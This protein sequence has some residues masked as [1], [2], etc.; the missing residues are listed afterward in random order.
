VAIGNN[1]ELK[2][3]VITPTEHATTLELEILLNNEKSYLL[4]AD[5]N[6]SSKGTER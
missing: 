1:L 2:I 5:S 3:E 4:L 6:Q